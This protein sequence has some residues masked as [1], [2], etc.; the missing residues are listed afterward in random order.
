MATKSNGFT[1]VCMVLVPTSCLMMG[2]IAMALPNCD[3]SNPTNGACGGYSACQYAEQQ[4]TPPSC[5]GNEIF[6][7][8]GPFRCTTPPDPPVGSTLCDEI[9]VPERTCTTKKTCTLQSLYVPPFPTLYWCAGT[10]SAQPNSV[11]TKIMDN[12]LCNDTSG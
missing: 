11:T 4:L 1:I 8:V 10:G 3:G 12:V 2:A 5:V 7:E 9:N 6:S